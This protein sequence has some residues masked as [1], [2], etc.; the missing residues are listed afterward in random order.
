M[1]ISRRK[2]TSKQL[3]SMMG[4]KRDYYEI[5]GLDRNATL[6]DIKRAYRKL[7]MQFHPDRVP[8]SKKK[9]AEEKFKEISEA[10][11]VLSDENKRRL[12]DQYGHAGI[13]SQFSTEDIFRS[14]NF[15]DIFGSSGFGSIF[16]DLFSDFG[17]DFFGSSRSSR[18]RAR[19]GRDLQVKVEVG[20]EEV[21]R[22]TQKTISFSRLQ[23][24]PSCGGGGAA[25][26]SGKRICPQCRG[27]G[28]V[29]TSAGFVRLGSTCPRCGGEGK[30]IDRP[31]PQCQGRG[32]VKV[33]RTLKV[34][35]PAGITEGSSLRLRGE[36]EE[37]E[38]GKGDLYV[39]I[40]I[41]RHPLFERDGVNILY[42]IKIS[43]L[44]AVLGG[45]VEV[46]T[47]EGKVEMQIPAG[48]QPG[49]VFRLK[50]K[51]LPDIHSRSQKRGDELVK[52]NIEVPR[53]LS[54]AE[55]EFWEK[56]AKLKGESISSAGGLREKIRKAFR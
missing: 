16:E 10:Y 11:A 17:F 53:R 20:L 33:R 23:L 24:C 8:E 46:E 1:P 37:A 12:Y 30:I 15:S 45:E 32:V 42:T 38:G 14:A 6:D 52:V 47:L 18:R 41:R 31:C 54:N 28:T 36:G 39:K 19:R 2:A 29:Y 13:D 22:G 9:E 55:R 27:T 40:G 26:G 34:N 56:L 21:L 51:G 4:T 49:T 44:K 5:L 35:I 48:T 7:A 3:N 50:G 43:V 25:A